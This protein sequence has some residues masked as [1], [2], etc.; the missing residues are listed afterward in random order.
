MDPHQAISEI[1]LLFLTIPNSVSRRDE[2]SFM[3]LLR[4]CSN[5]LM[6]PFN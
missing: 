6:H 4:F 5:T 3:L 2:M 1:V